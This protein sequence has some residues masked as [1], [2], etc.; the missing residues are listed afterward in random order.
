MSGGV[1]VI[2]ISGFTSSDPDARAAVVRAVDDACTEWGFLIVD[3]HGVSRRLIDEMA[4]VSRA[5]FDLPLATRLRYEASNAFTRRGYHR[6][7]S[8]ANA[9]TL[10]QVLPPD[11]RESFRAGPEAVAGD[12]YYESDDA[13]RFFLPN[14]WPEQPAEMR[15]IWQR[16]Y[17]AASDL[18]A[19]LMEIFAEAL[20]LPPQWFAGKIDRAISQ[21]VAQHYPALETPPLPGQ[22]RNGEHTDFGS[23][24]LLLAEDRPGGLQVQHT[25]GKWH[26][27]RPVPG[28]F[29]VNLG[30]MLAQWTND[31]W[32]STLHRVVNPPN[33]GAAESRRLSIV[34]FHQPNLEAM[35]DTIPSCITP[36]RP[37]Q[38]E[39]VSAGDYF[40]RKLDQVH[41]LTEKS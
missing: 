35:I 9:R 2:D 7:A 27:V 21:L 23:I 14:I 25:D 1:P 38:Y 20:A 32:R 37:L 17:A 34:F 24:T 30:D 36:Q 40:A 33:D 41:R 4:G 22:L 15:E 16:Y 31:R 39:P 11:L 13:R 18:A 29:I 26:D 5:F 10:G 28:T 8:G 6:F 19:R 12:A 3:G